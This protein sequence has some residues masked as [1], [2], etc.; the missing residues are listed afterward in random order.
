M[1]RM[2]STVPKDP[3]WK[4]SPESVGSGEAEVLLREYYIEVSDR[5]YQL[6]EGRSSTP[7]EIAEGLAGSPS[8]YL[9]PP[10][11]VFLI[12]RYRGDPAGCAGLRVLDA[13][14]V[15]LKRL[16][17]RPSAR[18]TGGGARILAAV[19]E[20]ARGLGAERIV[21][22]TRL[23]LI[24]ARSLYLRHGYT[25]IPAYSRQLYAEV[26]YGKELTARTAAPV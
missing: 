7:T 10:T 4:V 20:A 23:D 19:D 25:E 12:G 16:F 21:L 22:D 2:T 15:E 11:G 1:P 14:T 18:G 6:H 26:W 8:D 17:V 24:E 3:L 13:S 9:A 5:Y